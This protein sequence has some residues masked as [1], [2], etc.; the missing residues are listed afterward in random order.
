MTEVD[1]LLFDGERGCVRS[2][3]S[4]VDEFCCESDSDPGKS[5]GSIFTLSADGDAMP[6]SV[7][8]RVINLREVR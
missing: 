5:S 6:L 4:D 8:G 1:L 3:E 2:A 7:V